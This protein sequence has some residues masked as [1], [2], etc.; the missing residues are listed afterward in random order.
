MDLG[1]VEVFRGP[2]RTMLARNNLP[3]PLNN[4]SLS[5]GSLSHE[6]RQL[7]PGEDSKLTSV[8]GT[9]PDAF[10]TSL[11]S[12]GSVDT[13]ELGWLSVRRAL[14]NWPDLRSGHRVSMVAEFDPKH[15]AKLLDADLT[16][17]RA[18]LVV[19]SEERR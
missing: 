15:V 11:S 2:L 9:D 14:R 6:L 18:F 7:L 3:F 17:A 19:L 12:R 5:D 16:G 10:G 13:T 4:L 1:S 8:A